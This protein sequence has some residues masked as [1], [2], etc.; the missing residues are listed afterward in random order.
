[1]AITERIKKATKRA[2]KTAASPADYGI[3]GAPINRA[4]PSILDLLQL[5]VR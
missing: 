1:M 4:H 3:A 2:A 5:S